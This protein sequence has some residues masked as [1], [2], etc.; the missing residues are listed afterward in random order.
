MNFPG[1][2]RSGHLKA[3]AGILILFSIGLVGY[4]TFSADL[5][6][7]LEVTMEE[8]DAEEGDPVYTA[9]LDYGE[10]YG[11]AL[12]AGLMGFAVCLAVF[13]IMGSRLAGTR[14]ALESTDTEQ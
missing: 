3:A 10:N 4:F 8:G 1:T 5:G 13:R 12:L 7:G 6:D 14:E 9:P 2:I 11:A